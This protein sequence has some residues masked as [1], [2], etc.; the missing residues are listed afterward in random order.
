MSKIKAFPFWKKQYLFHDKATS[1]NTL[2]RLYHPYNSIA[3]LNWWL[4]R[5]FPIYQALFTFTLHD[6]SKL[7]QFIK[8][9]TDVN[10]DYQWAINRGTKTIYQKN[11][12]LFISNN[13]SKNIDEDFFFKWGDTIHAIES[14]KKEAELFI[15]LKN[16]PF[17]P[18]LLQYKS[19][20]NQAYYTTEIIHGSKY[21]SMDVNNEVLSLIH[22]IEEIH[23][24]QIKNYCLSTTLLTSFHHGDFGPWNLIVEEKTNI[25]KAIDWEFSGIYPKGFDLLYYIFSVEFLIRK[26]IA[27]ET[28]I[29]KNKSTIET[30]FKTKGIE[31]WMPYLKEFASICSKRNPN[32]IIGGHF[33][34]LI[35]YCNQA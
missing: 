22:K 30:Y 34:K 3:K 28:I 14:I 4:W 26:N 18:T 15:E 16:Q 12:G 2:L 1:N 31:D 10:P 21:T 20:S 6:H 5:N 33:D 11:T 23:I 27:M 25:I 24:P 32:T 7:N 35:N 13:R 17:A 8:K 9:F 29:N 19:D